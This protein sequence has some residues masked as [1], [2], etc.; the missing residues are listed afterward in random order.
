VGSFFVPSLGILT[1][2]QIVGFSRFFLQIIKSL[3]NLLM[4]NGKESLLSRRKKHV[5]K[6]REECKD[7]LSKMLHKDPKERL[8]AKEGVKEII[9][10]PWF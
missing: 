7:F 1:Y 2:E 8:G 10:H 9:E 4:H 6:M 5:I 3:E